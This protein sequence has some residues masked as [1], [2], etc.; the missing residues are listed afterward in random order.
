M[1]DLLLTAAQRCQ[2][3]H[4]LHTTHDAGVFRRTWAVLEAAHGR[5]IADIARLL[6]T[7]RPSVYTW[8]ARYRAVPDPASLLDHRGG[9]HP[10]RWTEA[11]RAALAA[12][13]AQPPDHFGYQAVGWTVPLLRE[14][15]TRWSGPP[16]SETSIRRQLHQLEY[17]WKRPRYV[18]APDPEAEKKTAAA[19]RTGRA[20]PPLCSAL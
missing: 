7:S 20:A 13:L 8:L 19:P 5:P 11:L 17:V 6:R 3:E 12:S 4:Q 14:H 1:G 18:L 9:N 15:L 10:T 2:L 16:L